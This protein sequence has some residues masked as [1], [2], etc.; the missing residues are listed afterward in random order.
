MNLGKWLGLRVLVGALW[1]KGGFLKRGGLDDV[2][3]RGG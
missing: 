3:W 1:E 2:V